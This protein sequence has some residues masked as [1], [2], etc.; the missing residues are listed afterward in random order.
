MIIF[1][2][3]VQGNVSLSL[4]LSLKKKGGGDYKLKP[5]IF[6][7][8]NSTHPGTGVPIVLAGSKLTS[9]QVV[10]SFGKIPK[11]RKIEIENKQ[12]P[13]EDDG[14]ISLGSSQL[15]VW[16]RVIF[17]VLFLFFYFFPQSNNG[18]TPASFIN[19]HL[20]NAFRVKGSYSHVDMI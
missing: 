15:W 16:L 20:P 6:C 13:L 2:L 11:A 8:N 5:N 9:D 7:S 18:Q 3:W 17:W 10:K 19:K 14:Q 1:S 4:S 12:A